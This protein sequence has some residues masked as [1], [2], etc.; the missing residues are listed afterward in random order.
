MSFKVFFLYSDIDHSDVVKSRDKNA[1]TFSE[2]N[3]HEWGGGEGG[4]MTRN[5]P[6][7]PG[8]SVSGL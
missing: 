3:G 5:K 4:V 8:K 2:I 6:R 1:I 7:V